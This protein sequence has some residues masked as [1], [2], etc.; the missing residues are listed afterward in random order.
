MQ[1]G[2]NDRAPEPSP[3]VSIDA[4]PSLTLLIRMQNGDAEAREE[5]VRRYWPRLQRWARGRLPAGA[6]DLYDTTDLVQETMLMALHRLDEFE[7]EHDGALQAYLRV[8]ILNRIRTLAKRAR[9]RGEKVELDS[10]ITDRTPSP[11]EQAVGREAVERY[12][13]ALGRLRSDDRHAIQLKIELDL[14]YPDIARELG[15]PTVTAA[16]MAVS[17]ALARLAREMQHA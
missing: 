13:R 10:G 16:R 14:P 8:A 15:K 17:R 5:L 11:L 3:A 4:L 2:E 7:P 1:D 12:E 6:R 9:T